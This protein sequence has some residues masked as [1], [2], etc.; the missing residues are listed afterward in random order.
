MGIK[1]RIA[2]CL[3]VLV[4]CISI[5]H[6]SPIIDD[7]DDV[8]ALKNVRTTDDETPSASSNTPVEYNLEHLIDGKWVKRAIISCVLSP[9]KMRSVIE[10]NACMVP[11]DIMC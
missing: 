3:L 9:R 8:Y 1:Q 10:G 7:D 2:L 4:I 6:T 11:H 5:V